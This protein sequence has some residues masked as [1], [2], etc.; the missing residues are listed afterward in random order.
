MRLL[1]Y[2]VFILRFQT[3]E[4]AMILSTSPAVN[5]TR[6]NPEKFTPVKPKAASFI[7]VSIATF[8]DVSHESPQQ[9]DLLL[10]ST[11][12]STL[13]SSMHHH[14]TPIKLA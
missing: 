1:N 4:S 6:V 8:H 10:S 5:E 2:A 14:R 9:A 11:I 3:K 12:I 13:L 7:S